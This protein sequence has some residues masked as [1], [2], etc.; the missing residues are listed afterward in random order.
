M[1]TRS[2]AG[3]QGGVKTACEYGIN[4]YLCPEFGGICPRKIDEKSEFYAKN[5]KLGGTIVVKKYGREHMS[6]I[7]KLGGRGNKR[8][9]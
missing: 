5:G 6:R 4:R 1:T 3:R 8:H 7:G 2:E 9:E